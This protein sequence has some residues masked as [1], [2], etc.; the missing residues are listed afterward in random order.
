MNYMNSGVHSYPDGSHYEGQWLNGMR[1]GH[2][3][4]SKSDGSTYV[5]EWEDDKPHGQGTLTL[6]NGK[7]HTGEWR[8]GKRHGSGVEIF[9]DGTK[10]FG[11]WE[12]GEE[13]DERRPINS[14]QKYPE[15]FEETKH[16]YK[17]DLGY[18]QKPPYKNA[19]IWATLLVIALL[20]LIVIVFQGKLYQV[21]IGE[22][23]PETSG[24]ITGILE[25][26]PKNVVDTYFMEIQRHNIE[27][28]F[29]LYDPYLVEELGLLDNINYT[30]ESFS[31]L[32][33]EQPLIIYSVG[34][35]IMLTD[36]QAIVEVIGTVLYSGEYE[37][38]I[39]H[40][41][42]IQRNGVW[43]INP[44]ELGNF[45]N[46]GTVTEETSATQ[47]SSLKTHTIVGLFPLTGILST[48]GE[49]SMEAARLA[50]TDVNKWLEAEGRNW[51]LRFEIDDTA[52]EGPVGL[53]KMQSWFG[54]GVMFFAGPL[55][56]GV[57]R[58]CLDFANA[59]QILIISPS[60]T[61]PA[62]AI[63]NDWLF[64]FCYDETIDTIQ[65][66][67]VGDKS[68]REYVR[69]HIISKL[70]REPDEEFAYNTYDIIWALALSIDRVGYNPQLVRTVLPD[71]VEEWSSIYGASGKIV[72]NNA[73]DRVSSY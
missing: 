65:P 63:E 57:V 31:K 18:R 43:Y 72:L 29:A 68:Y 28:A 19:I 47:E 33:E 20:G 3:I 66:P 58:D 54:E 15:K 64:R 2:G 70:G 22:S 30:I 1:H 48:Y 59:N 10:R 55:A 71:I 52:T 45:F 51:R 46:S 60:S 38:R 21:F 62:L 24:S 27:G 44:E 67:V 25:P 11:E 7:K 17:G 23:E 9:P 8:N 34:D 32:L 37:E 4:W 36:S 73:G 6:P 42:V 40:I 35:T 39:T 12:D 49:N 16:D 41:P 56:S 53:R 69:N 14:H 50:A 13:V 26:N 61:H 5:G